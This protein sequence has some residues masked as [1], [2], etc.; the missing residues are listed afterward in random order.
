MAV[1]IKRI[2]SL[3]HFWRVALAFAFAF[4]FAGAQARS[5]AYPSKPVRIVV[6]IPA[7]GNVDIIARAVA[8]KLT[9]NWHKQVIVENRPGASTIIGSEFVAKSA[10]DGY[11]LL[12]NSA[13]NL[14]SNPGLYPK[15][16]YDTLRDFTPIS[17]IARVAL[18]L[19]VH[20][21]LPVKSVKE[22]IALAK[23]R[24]GELSVGNGSMGSAG[25]LALELFMSM[26]ATRFVPVPY[27]GNA[28]ALA[29]TIA[30]HVPMM[31]DTLSTSIT[32]VKGGRLRALG[33]TSPERSP[34]LPDIPTVAE[35]ALPGYEASV[36]IGLLGP[37]A[38]PRDIVGKVSSEVAS[39]ARDPETRQQFAQEGIELI[40]STQEA[41]A[42]F[43]RTDIAKWEKLIREAGIKID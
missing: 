25:H 17:N 2:R 13:G 24:P 41:F 4:A 37:A 1:S 19:V 6:P 30:G 14:T 36:Y 29:D 15:L 5:P 16:P 38:M 35:A 26:S 40:G 3:R 10:P 28:P 31:I 12:I 22:L 34:L 8:Q 23:A 32:H 42:T 11:T 21:S 43:M 9:E 33:V 27:K 39:I 7:G 20:P 18:I